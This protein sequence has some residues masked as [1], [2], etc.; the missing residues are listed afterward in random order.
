[1]RVTL[2]IID[3]QDKYQFKFVVDGSRW[4]INPELPQSND[5]KGNINNELTVPRE[6][7]G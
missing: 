6:N 2:P 4:E 5:G 1:V 7:R 3:G